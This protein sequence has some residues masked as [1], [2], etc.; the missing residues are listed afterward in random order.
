MIPARLFPPS[1]DLQARGAALE[2]RAPGTWIFRL[3]REL[4]SLNAT[5]WGHWRNAAAEREA[6]EREFEGA[7]A[8]FSVARRVEGWTRAEFDAFAQLRRQRELRRVRVIRLVP[9]ARHLLGDD[10]NLRACDKH[11][12]DAMRHVGLIHN[13]SR[14]W[15]DHRAPTQVLAEDWA[16]WTHVQLDRPDARA[17]WR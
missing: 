1:D 14:T 17:V 2:F 6:W 13:D 15:L 11:L 9:H 5:M 12:V 8:A 7:I 10:G 16:W 3:P 4:R